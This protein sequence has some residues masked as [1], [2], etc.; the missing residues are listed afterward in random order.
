VRNIIKN[1]CNQITE[2]LQHLTP[3]AKHKRAIAWIGLAWKWVECNPDQYD[4]TVMTEHINGIVN[5]NTRRI[6][7]NKDFQERINKSTDKYNQWQV[8]KNSEDESKLYLIEELNQI[9]RTMDNIFATIHIAKRAIVNQ[10]YF[11]AATMQQATAW[12]ETNNSSQALILDYAKII[13]MAPSRIEI[14][15]LSSVKNGIYCNI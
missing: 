9:Q 4:F 5:N 10:A 11:E 12:A 6:V 7:T 14:I 8:N 13:S 2:S 15:G 3:T 1:R